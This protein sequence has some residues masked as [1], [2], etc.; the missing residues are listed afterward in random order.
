MICKCGCDHWL[1]LAMGFQGIVGMM[2]N[3]NNQS[4]R[5]SSAAMEMLDTQM[6]KLAAEIEK[7]RR[8]NEATPPS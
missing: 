5:A 8:K 2:V 7:Q 1:H 4:V 6:A 3:L